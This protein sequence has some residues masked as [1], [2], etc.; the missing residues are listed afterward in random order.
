MQTIPLA[1]T[2]QQSF[3][4]V[5]DS[6]RYVLSLRQVG[7]LMAIDITLNGS[8]VINGHRCI[9]NQPVIPYQYLEGIGGN[10]VWV[11]P[12]GEYPNWNQF[13]ITHNLIYV[14]VAELATLRA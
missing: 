13:G 10:F 8:N 9:P 14:T 12:N 3:P 7:D 1:I 5:L 11:T 2:A 4:I 6:Q